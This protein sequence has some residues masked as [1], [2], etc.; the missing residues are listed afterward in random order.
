MKTGLVIKFATAWTRSPAP[1]T[2]ALPGRG[3]ILDGWP[4]WFYVCQRTIAEL[5][6]SVRLLVEREHL[7]VTSDE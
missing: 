3:L 6:L 4:G 2:G 5:M 1:E 7:E